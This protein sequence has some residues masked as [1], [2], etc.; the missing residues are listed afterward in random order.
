MELKVSHD[1][2]T[3]GDLIA[4]G[5]DGAT[6]MPLASLADL[7]R[8]VMAR[9]TMPRVPAVQEVARVL[10]S[11]TQAPELFL[12]VPG[13]YAVPLPPGYVFDQGVTE[14]PA[15]WVRRGFSAAQWGD[16]APSFKMKQAVKGRPALVGLD[17][18]MAWIEAAWAQG[19]DA[20]KWMKQGRRAC[21]A[22]RLDVANTL[23]GFGPER[24]F[25]QSEPTQAPRPALTE[26]HLRQP[27][28]LSFLPSHDGAKWG[29]NFTNEP[30]PRRLIRLAD[31]VQAAAP[32]GRAHAAG[33]SL[34]RA[35]DWVLDGLASA[36]ASQWFVLDQVGDPRHVR[37][38][39]VWRPGIPSGIDELKA[40]YPKLLDNL[41]TAAARRR[42][43]A[44]DADF[45]AAIEADAQ[46]YGDVGVLMSV[47]R[48]EYAR[49]DA[50]HLVPD[51]DSA[52]G[53]YIS[54]EEYAALPAVRELAGVEGLM[55]WLRIQWAELLK[56]PA[57][58]DAGPTAFVAIPA[59]LV[60]ALPW[61][62]AKAER[63]ALALVS[64]SSLEPANAS[65]DA[66][67]ALSNR[68]KE[69]KA[70]PKNGRRWINANAAKLLMLEQYNER[71]QMPHADA[72]TAEE[73]IGSVWG[74]AKNTV[75]SYLT[76]A[77]KLNTDRSSAEASAERQ[78]SA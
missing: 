34:K 38:S 70:A 62:Q 53:W 41:N 47:D 25:W 20:E 29:H 78:Q 8:N 31:V 2:T 9:D 14:T 50:L 63:P 51:Q 4:K 33:L 64:A 67:V 61:I 23:F 46:S 49:R 12:T 17:G 74:L 36:D 10:R 26:D 13:N 52:S 54:L 24:S 35:A 73:Q 58:L 77:R 57:D 65:H 30:H 32:V 69:H 21:L 15:Q 60:A 18:A 1:S 39:D 3:L 44:T 11:A 55:D 28:A 45:F 42:V 48:E 16:S 37:S 75:H 40:S 59:E 56:T 68:I 27:S 7:V 66:I 19:K 6:A 72:D 43:V 5:A 76:D 22:I 71:M